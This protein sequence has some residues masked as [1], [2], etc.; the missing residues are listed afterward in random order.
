MRNR[1]Y[2]LSG[3]CCHLKKEE[4]F[5]ILEENTTLYIYSLILI[6]FA[7]SIHDQMTECSCPMTQQPCKMKMNACTVTE[8]LCE[9]YFSLNSTYQLLP[10]LWEGR[11]KNKRK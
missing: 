4:I 7:P 10:K 2:N 6:K 3:C 11:E 1:I 5:I 8:F 9:S